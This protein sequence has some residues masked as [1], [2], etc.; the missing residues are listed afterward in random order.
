MGM[1]TNV[2]FV[3]KSLGY[4]D[5]HD[6][7]ACPTSIISFLHKIHSNALPLRDVVLGGNENFK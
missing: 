1:K 3:E 5:D 7:H 4:L 2:I 6:D